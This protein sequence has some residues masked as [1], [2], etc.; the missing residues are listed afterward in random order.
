MGLH[1]TAVERQHHSD[2]VVFGPLHVLVEILIKLRIFRRVFRRVRCG[3]AHAFHTELLE[4]HQHTLVH[5]LRPRGIEGIGRILH[6]SGV[7]LHRTDKRSSEGATMPR[8]FGDQRIASETFGDRRGDRN[9]LNSGGRQVDFDRGIAFV[10]DPGHVWR[11]NLADRR[12]G[13]VANRMDGALF[14]DRLR[15][16]IR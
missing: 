3:Q 13:L 12:A 16:F 9:V 4:Q 1:G 14:T 10:R 8:D 11:P 6:T 2:V 7:G 15:R 5:E